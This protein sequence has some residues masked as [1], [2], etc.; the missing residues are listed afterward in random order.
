MIFSH[1]NALRQAFPELAA[2]VIHAEGIHAQA[3]VDAALARHT[4][5]ALALL[6]GRTESDLPAI[7]AW[8]R[9]FQRMG[10]KPTQY[11]CAS[12]ALL[13]RLRKEGDLPR[14]HP[15][16]DLCNALSVAHAIP[17]AAL[18]LDRVSGNLQVRHAD[19]S[20]DYL[21][22]SGEHEHPEPG[23]VTFADDAGRSHARRWT[24]RQSALSA[25]QP[26]TARVLIVAEALHAGAADDVRRLIDTLGS[27]LQALFG[28]PVRSAMLSNEAPGF[29]C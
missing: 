7:Q 1:S 5:S 9:A 19:G 28:V 4:A 29:E 15:L 6:Q 2:G 8:R 16:V 12:E 20:E 3:Q 11:R 22:F 17:V 24:N 25:I 21:S 18:D 23:E 26:S 13:R 14:L 27:E 10:L